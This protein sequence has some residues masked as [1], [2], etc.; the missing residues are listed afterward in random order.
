MRTTSLCRFAALLTPLFG[1]H[2]EQVLFRAQEW[3]VSAPDR[4]DC[5]KPVLTAQGPGTLFQESNRSALQEIRAGI[6]PGVT[7]QCPGLTEAILVS[8][9]TRHLITLSVA[10]VQKCDALL[11]WLGRVRQEYPQSPANL[12]KAI[13]V[14]RDQDFA[15]VFGRP[16]D[17]TTPA[18]RAD[19]HKNVI[20][21]C[22]SQLEPFR[23]L[24]DGPFLGQAGPFSPAAVS[25]A[26]AQARQARDWMDRSL[27][28]A[29]LQELDGRLSQSRSQLAALWPSEQQSFA[30]A[31]AA[32]RTDLTALAADNWIAEIDRFGN[33]LEEARRLGEERKLRASLIGAADAARQANALAKYNAKLDAIVEPLVQARVAELTNIPGTLAGAKQSAEWLTAFNR[34]FQ[35]YADRAGVRAAQ[36]SYTSNRRRI[37]EQ[38]LPEWKKAVGEADSQALS[39]LVPPA[40]PGESIYSDYQQALTA[41]VEKK[42]QAEFAASAAK[43]GQLAATP[44]EKLNASAAIAACEPAA[45]ANN[46]PARLRFQLARGYLKA[47]RFE[48]AAEQ[49]V[50][51]AKEGHGPS[52]A[53]LGDLL[54]NGAPGIEADAALAHS[55]YERAVEAGYAPAK[56][57]LAK[58]EDLTDKAAAIDAAQEPE[59]V[60]DGPPAAPINTKYINPDIVENIDKGALDAVPTG[61]RYTKLYLYNMAE[62]ISEVCE[63]HF[64][65]SEIS[66]LNLDAT[67]KSVDL[68]TQGTTAL[69]MGSLMTLAQA[70]KNPQAFIQ[71]AAQSEVDEDALWQEAMKDAFALMMRHPCKGPDLTR[72]S[73]NLVRY[74]HDEG[75]PRLST[76]AMFNLCSREAHPTGRYDAKNF[77][78]CFT[79]ALALAP[80]SRADRKALSSDF[81]NTAQKLMAKD[82]QR[83]GMCS[84]R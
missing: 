52:L 68:S 24:L 57:V 29:S 76:D 10:P 84:G 7:R 37:L 59:L 55:L 9:R 4:I 66:Q 3:V 8:G 65:K 48:E 6:A 75:A 50:A 44:D 13:Y 15:P 27:S 16:Y 30:K 40:A 23:A 70:M 2:A 35:P 14:Y 36:Q 33:T 47:G 18:W 67:L 21:R 32:R 19:V 25:A 5:S 53:Y 64:T 31:I 51:G 1:A 79:S 71:Q 72:F 63:A 42:Q 82:R 78:S 17:Q 41:Q 62:N 73:K 77:C 61:E 54:L 28:A 74:I 81:W 12:E 60:A 56:A 49:L 34:D 11:T 39:K 45:K 83:Y 69:A 26:I 80:I 38:A 58:F 22:A 20:S 43:C 46:A